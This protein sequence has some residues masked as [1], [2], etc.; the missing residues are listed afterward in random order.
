LPW[1]LAFDYPD[2][3][4]VLDNLNVGGPNEGDP[5]FFDRDRGK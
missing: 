1:S 3:P 5:E 4:V 2:M